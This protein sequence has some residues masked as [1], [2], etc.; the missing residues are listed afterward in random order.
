MGDCKG[1]GRS[2]Q[3]V[4]WTMAVA[5]AVSRGKE[6]RHQQRAKGGEGTTQ[7]GDVLFWIKR[8]DDCLESSHEQQNDDE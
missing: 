4:C 2:I 6:G 3:A 1:S 8:R 5:T 7:E